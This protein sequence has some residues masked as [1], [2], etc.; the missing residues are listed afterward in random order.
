VRD[1][2]ST[3]L[4]PNYLEVTAMTRRWRSYWCSA[5]R[6][7]IKRLGGQTYRSYCDA[8]DR[9]VLMRAVSRKR[10]AK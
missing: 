3:E 10:K 4:K 1:L 2:S 9:D 7:V 6:R 5:C 8:T